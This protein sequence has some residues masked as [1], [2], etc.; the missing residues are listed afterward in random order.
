M[1]AESKHNSEGNEIRDLENL[2][3][4]LIDI[5]AALKDKYAKGKIQEDVYKHKM[6][7][8][9]QKRKILEA[10]FDDSVAELILD[11]NEKPFDPLAIQMEQQ[12]QAMLEQERM[13]LEEPELNITAVKRG[14]LN[15]ARALEI[16][17][18]C[19]EKECKAIINSK[20]GK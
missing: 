10:R 3:N 20:K 9:F 19:R 15:D 6:E 11:K 5:E 4:Q 13:G 12:E 18:L 14:I 1:N 17:F 16:R 2:L 8:V 7:L